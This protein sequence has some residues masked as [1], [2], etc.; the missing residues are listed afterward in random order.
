MSSPSV[1]TIGKATNLTG[2]T[3]G[4]LTFVSFHSKSTKGHAL[5][6][7]RCSCGNEKVMRASNIISGHAKRC[8]KCRVPRTGSY[9]DWLRVRV[10]TASNGCWVWNRSTDDAGYGTAKFQGH[11]T[12]AHVMT[13]SMLVGSIPAGIK[14]LHKCDNRPCCNPDHLFLGTQAENMADMMAKQ[15]QARGERSHWAKLTEADVIEIRERYEAGGIS[16]RQLSMDYPVMETTIHAIVTR[17]LWKH[18]P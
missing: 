1:A 14:V 3:K 17:K 15:R 18:V 13:Y 7:C 10:N 8:G 4:E 16:Y 9:A 12:K 5:W 6:L 11:R 2:V